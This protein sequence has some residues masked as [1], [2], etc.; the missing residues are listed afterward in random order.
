MQL[1]KFIGLFW[2]KIIRNRDIMRQLND[3]WV[4]IKDVWQEGFLGINIGQ[5]IIAIFITVLFILIRG[6]FSRFILVTFHRI[7]SRTKSQ[8]DDDLLNATGPPIRF[9]PIILGIFIST[10]YLSLEGNLAAFSD[11]FCA[12]LAF[13]LY[14]GIFTQKKQV[15]HAVFMRYNVTFGPYLVLLAGYCHSF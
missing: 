3:F 6:L 1:I 4:L 11:N 8:I 5:I 12:I 2:G 7:A 15:L 9:I 14:Y 10:E 13:I